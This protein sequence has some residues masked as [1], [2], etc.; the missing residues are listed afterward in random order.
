MSAP[1][2]RPAFA[3]L[4]PEKGPTL[5]DLAEDAVAALDK[6]R[7]NPA[8]TG[9]AYQAALDDAALDARQALLDHLLN[10]HGIGTTLAG[11]IGEVL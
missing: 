10:E 5:R 11:R 8:W 3:H 4:L 2:T 7:S 9:T 1:V 6:A